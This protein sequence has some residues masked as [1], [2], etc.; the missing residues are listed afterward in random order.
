MFKLTVH[1][2]LATTLRNFPFKIG[3]IEQWYKVCF[4]DRAK[5]TLEPLNLNRT[6][7][8]SCEKVLPCEIYCDMARQKGLQSPRWSFSI[9][10]NKFKLTFTLS[11]ALWYMPY[12]VRPCTSPTEVHSFCSFV[13][14]FLARPNKTVLMRAANVKTTLAWWPDGKQTLTLVVIQSKLSQAP[15]PVN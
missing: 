15:N 13:S 11:K 1:I 10:V 3:E 7:K 9:K 2:L 4:S 5:F 14:K 12:D 6:H 8:L